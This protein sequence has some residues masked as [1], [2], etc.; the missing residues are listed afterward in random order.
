MEGHKGINQIKKIVVC[1]DVKTCVRFAPSYGDLHTYICN[2]KRLKE[3][4][5]VDF[6]HQ[7]VSIVSDCHN[8]GI[9]LRDL[10]LRKFVFSD[11][12]RFV[13]FCFVLFV[14]FYL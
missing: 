10:K 14:C 1:D 7:I 2:K 9:I 6:F 8:N 4:E 11:P 5:A 12:Q 13:L 3:S